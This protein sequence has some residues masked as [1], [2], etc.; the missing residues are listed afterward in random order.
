MAKYIDIPFAINGNKT[1]I[2]G[3]TTDGTVNYNDGFGAD[4]AK[5]IGTDPAAKSVDRETI[6]QVLFDI[7]SATKSLQDGAFIVDTI[8]DLRAMTEKPDTVYV[9]GYHTAGDGAFGSHFFKRVDSAGTDNTGTI[10]VP[11]GV[12][13]YY[14]ALQYGGAVNVK[15]FGAVGDG[16]VN[17]STSI[18]AAVEYMYLLSSL[19]SVKYPLSTSNYYSPNIELDFGVGNYKIDSPVIIPPKPLDSIVNITFKSNG[20]VLIG[21]NNVCFDFD[22]NSSGDKEKFSNIQFVNFSTAVKWQSNNKNES[23]LLFENCRFLNI[24][25]WAIDTVSYAKSRSTI[26]AIRDCYFSDGTIGAIR[27]YT[28]H[29]SISNSWIYGNDT[30]NTALIYISGD[31]NANISDS[32]FVPH[33]NLPISADSRFIDFVSYI[34]ESTQTNASL[35][36]LTISNCRASL[37]AVRGFIKT[38]TDYTQNNDA[39]ERNEAMSI[40]L[41]NSYIACGGSTSPI[42]E[43]MQGYVNLISFENIRSISSGL[44]GV[45]AANS[46][47]PLSP[48][49]STKHITYVIKIDETTRAS[50]QFANRQILP[51]ELMKFYYDT[52][53]Q[54]S[55]YQMSI[56]GDINYR[57]QAVDTSTSGVCK[58]TIPFNWEAETVTNANPLT[59]L[60]VTINDANGSSITPSYNASCTTIVSIVG[61]YISSTVVWA[62]KSA[63]LLDAQGGSNNGQ[64]AAP[65]SIFWGTGD[66]GSSDQDVTSTNGDGNNITVTWGNQNSTYSW[67]YIMPLSGI[68]NNQAWLEQNNVW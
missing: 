49:F 10:I 54:T 3:T 51:S 31:C 62:I 5:P 47:P 15:W 45:N 18:L 44:V 25:K 37:E 16:S 7:S 41:K 28:D 9:T 48:T 23:Q 52:T 14:Y 4:Y 22:T 20:A 59:F 66:S 27:S 42:V 61:T 67:M 56:P 68:R 30:S 26:M 43:H 24:S 34:A 50:N 13:T 21:S 60:L 53:S 35:K 19:T 63:T 65:T 40:I 17:S 11:N 33:P 29:L 8:T 12:T 38:F 58:A 6:N 2:P 32:F 57:I 1:A 39:G 46:K 36:S 55:K 64:S